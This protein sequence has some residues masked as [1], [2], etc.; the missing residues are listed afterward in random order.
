MTAFTKLTR[1]PPVATFLSTE[2][3][4]KVT[5]FE[6]NQNRALDF[7][8]LQGH[9]S[10]LH[11][12]ADSTLRANREHACVAVELD[13]LATFTKQDIFHRANGLL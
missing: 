7:R 6:D 2:T 1:T 9:I 4:Q 8:S 10:A 12:I 11:P 5:F 3:T 13:E